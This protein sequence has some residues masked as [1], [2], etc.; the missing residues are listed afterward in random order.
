RTLVVDVDERAWCLRRDPFDRF[1]V[2]SVDTA[3]IEGLRTDERIVQVR[4]TAQ[5]VSDLVNDQIT[6]IG[7]MTAGALDLVNGR[8]GHLLD[9]WLVLR[10]VLD[11][12]P[13]YRP[14]SV[15]LP[16]DLGRSFTLD[17]D[18]H[19]IRAYLESAGY[20]HLRGVFTADEMAR[21]SAD[22]DR[23]APSF[24]PGDGR[25][26]W[27]TLADGSEQVVRMQHFESHSP[28]LASILDDPRFLS[29]ADLVGAGHTVDWATGNRAEALFKPIG[30]ASGISDVPWHKDC[31]LGRHSY[32][33]CSLTVGIS[34]TGAGPT[35]GQLRVIAG[36][37]RALLWPSLIDTSKLDLP[38]VALPTDIGDVTVHL[39]CTLHMAQ[40]PTETPRRVVYTGFRLPNEADEQ[41]LA[42]N[43]Q[44]LKTSRE[45]APLNTSQVSATS[46]TSG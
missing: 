43:R 19:E 26:W 21:I 3:A 29:I 38:D 30:V 6:P 14:G 42:A 4:L 9:W 12:V 1:S 35:S 11:G 41:S 7:M 16:D 5:Q 32:E 15:D 28:T 25:S 37:H 17:D 24:S 18:P 39:S 8:I 31:S 40:E 36:S 20:L 33:C 44:R 10:S 34:I 13:I 22:M 46:S 45:G 23:A 2:D 27:A